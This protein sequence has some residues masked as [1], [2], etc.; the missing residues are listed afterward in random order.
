M[1]PS[2]FEND[3]LVFIC[4]R[5]LVLKCKACDFMRFVK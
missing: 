1:E 3:C 5:I 4:S 2:I